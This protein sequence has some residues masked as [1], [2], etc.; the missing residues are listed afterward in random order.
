M[1][2]KRLLEGVKELTDRMTFGGHACLFP[3]WAL[4][5]DGRWEG[6]FLASRFYAPSRDSDAFALPCDGSHTPALGLGWAHLS[7][8]PPHLKPSPFPFNDWL[9]VAEKIEII[10]SY[11]SVN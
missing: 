6:S 7:G 4:S 5:S 9:S 11:T 2:D 1:I 8:P 3:V 10:H